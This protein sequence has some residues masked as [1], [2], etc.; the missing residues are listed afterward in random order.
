MNQS[1]TNSFVMNR[2]QK[3]LKE[4]GIADLRPSQEA[5]E[6]MGVKYPTWRLWVDNKKDPEIAQLHAIAAFLGCSVC[7]LIQETETARV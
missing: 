6:S 3:I 2:I 7:E 4:K 1:T 5:L